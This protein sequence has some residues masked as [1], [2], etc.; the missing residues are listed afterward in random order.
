MQDKYKKEFLKEVFEHNKAFL[1]WCRE[2]RRASEKELYTWETTNDVNCRC[3]ECGMDNSP[4]FD[5][6][7]ELDAIDFSVYLCND[8]RYLSMLFDELGDQENAKYFRT[9]HEDLKEK[10]NG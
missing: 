5:Y 1:N 2:N 3:D 9:V 4:R 6:D 10:I 8:A 7:I